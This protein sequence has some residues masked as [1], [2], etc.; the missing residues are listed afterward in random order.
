M[1]VWELERSADLVSDSRDLSAGHYFR[2]KCE[3][4]S[5]FV[6]NIGACFE[7]RPSLT[8][9]LQMYCTLQLFILI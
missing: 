5:S 3:Q 6:V 7:L 4:G 8:I 1:S 2:A 9:G